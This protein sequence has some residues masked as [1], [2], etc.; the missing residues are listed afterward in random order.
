MPS[1]K[2]IQANKRNAIKS[3]GPKTTEGKNIARLNAMKHGLLSQE[4]LLPTED[5]EDFI[6]LRESLIT[7][8]KPEGELENLLVDQVV[9][10]VWRLRRMQHIETGIL[11]QQ[12]YEIKA[13]QAKDEARSLVYEPSIFSLLN[14]TDDTI[15]TNERRH[16]E[17]LR[18]EK[19]A[20][21]MAETELPTLGL[22]FI[23]SQDALSKLSRYQVTIEHSLYKALAELERLQ[24]KRKIIDAPMVVDVFSA[25]E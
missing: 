10:A 24:S 11:N 22:A 17:A 5:A 15:I 3:T 4:L 12:Y 21:E 2:Q 13:K 20:K 18:K 19:E 23:K 7:D 9:S 25:P 1:E 6:K 14:L 16:K 8:L